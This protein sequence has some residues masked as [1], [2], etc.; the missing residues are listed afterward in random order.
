MMHIAHATSG[1]KTS[2]IST[3]PTQLCASEI[4]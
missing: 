2:Y 4:Y 3:F 1:K